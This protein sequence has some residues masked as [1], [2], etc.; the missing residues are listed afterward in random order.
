[1][2]R[3]EKLTA[4]IQN[5]LTRIEE[6]DN[7]VRE[8]TK[9]SFSESK[10]AGDE[11]LELKNLLGHGKWLTH[12]RSHFPKSERTAQDCMLIASNWAMLKP[13][14]DKN[15]DLSKAQALDFL[16]RQKKGIDESPVRAILSI[17]KQLEAGTTAKDV[18]T[19]SSMFAFKDGRA[20]TFNDEIAC[21]VPQPL[22]LGEEFTGAV[23]AASLRKF[24]TLVRDEE[25]AFYVDDG[26]FIV[27][28]GGARAG[29]KVE[30]EVVLAI[31]RVSLPHEWKPLPQGFA[32]AF[33]FVSK[34]IGKDESQYQTN[35]IHIAKGFIE[36][37]D[38]CQAV[39][40]KF[41]LG[42]SQPCLVRGTSLIPAISINPTEFGET[43][44]WIHFRNAD[45][46]VY[47][48]RRDSQ[49]YE[50]FD[51]LLNV[52]GDRFV[53]TDSLVRCVK[54]AEVFSSQ[55]SDNN[56]VMI[57]LSD[58]IA[59]VEAQ[60]E[61]GWYCAGIPTDYGGE[62]VRF[63]IGPKLLVEL[64][65]EKRECILSSERLKIETPEYEY[66]VALGNVE[67]FF[68]SEAKG[69]R[70]NPEKAA[71]IKREQYEEQQRRIDQ[72]RQE[73]LPWWKDQY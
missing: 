41:D 17:F 16:R 30:S 22:P 64:A 57:D 67:L 1:M 15:P 43:E 6:A 20:F 18:I 21:S 60:G 71:L 5:R 58:E 36:A 33:T 45:G 46:F 34:C 27:E 68:A 42:L 65:K 2:D 38:N 25:V 51:D 48:C 32:D 19:Q 40:Y 55:N 3:I 24:L 52:E 13:R 53:I 12:V 26:D 72:E 66:I 62:P 39:R 44:E 11:L 56:E 4:R 31:D 59:T 61:S 9:F 14:R 49:E 47:S 50:P 54:A 35:C 69:F 70:P 29:F 73:E 63:S 28:A 23:D 8:A 10:I 7:V 37:C